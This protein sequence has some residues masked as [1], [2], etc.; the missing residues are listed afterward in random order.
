MEVCIKLDQ[1]PLFNIDGIT[2]LLTTILNN[3]ITIM[4]LIDD[5]KNQVSGLQTQAANLQTSLDNEQAQIAALLETNAQVVTDL[6]TQI[7]TLKDQIA[8]GAT[9]EQL[10]EVINGI[11]AITENIATTKTDLEGTVADT[12][13]TP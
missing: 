3:Q 6:N 10:Q 13:P 8:A 12:Q 5:L 9:P 2:E 1:P 4:A 11:A 7:A